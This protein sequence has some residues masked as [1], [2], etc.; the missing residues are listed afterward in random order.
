[1]QHGILRTEVEEYSKALLADGEQLAMSMDTQPHIEMMNLA[2]ETI[3][4]KQVL[5]SNV[6]AQ[7]VRAV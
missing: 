3:S 1:M 5:N 2:I 6:Q 4:N 7:E